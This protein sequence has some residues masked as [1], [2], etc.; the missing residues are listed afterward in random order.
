MAGGLKP[1]GF[2]FMNI[3]K[4]NNYPQKYQGNYLRHNRE[5][6]K[7]FLEKNVEYL[8]SKENISYEQAYALARVFME[9][10]YGIDIDELS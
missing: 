8:A 2:L 9:A 6:A 3:K 1:L 4:F 10:C 5:H 7:K